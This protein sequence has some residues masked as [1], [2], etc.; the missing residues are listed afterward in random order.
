MAKRLF[1][2]PRPFP[3]FF[4]AGSGVLPFQNDGLAG[5]EYFTGTPGVGLKMGP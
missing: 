1:I 4:N 2:V 3:F 5:A